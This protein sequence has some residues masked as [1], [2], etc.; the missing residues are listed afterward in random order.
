MHARSGLAR[1]PLLAA[2]LVAAP[3]LAGPPLVTDDPETLPKGHFEFNTAYTLTL[4]ARGGSSGRTWEHETPLLD[5]S[6]GFLEGVQLKFEVPI[7]ALDPSDHTHARAGVGD[8]SVGSKLRF[9]REDEFPVSISIYPAFGIPIGNRAQGL[10]S[11][12]PSITFP[13]Q[14]GRHLLN[15]KLFLYAD[16]GYREHFAA[17]EPDFWYAGIAAEY[18]LVEGLTLCAELHAEFAGHGQPDDAL[19]NLGLK[20]TLTEDAA[21]IGSAGRSFNPTPDSGAD[22]VLYVGI[23]W[24]F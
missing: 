18:Q 2:T 8:A 1:C 11:G 17:G 19:F 6:F 3:A 9:V 15:D 24:S 12:S 20:Y 14:I 22:L 21:F 4:S 5:L 7:I 16:A 10:G 23:Q 13:I